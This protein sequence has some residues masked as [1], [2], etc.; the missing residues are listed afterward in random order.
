MKHIGV[1]CQRYETKI[2]IEFDEATE[3][4]KEM[5]MGSIDIRPLA[6]ILISNLENELIFGK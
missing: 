2:L 6:S 1:R 5:K 4:I 3:Y